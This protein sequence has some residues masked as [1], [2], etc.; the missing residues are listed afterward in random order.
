MLLKKA[1]L[2]LL[3]RNFR[4]VSNLGCISKLH[5]AATQHINHIESNSLMEKHQSAYHAL[6]STETVLLKVKTD[7]IRALENHEVACLVFLDLSTAFNTIDYNILLIRMETLFAVT[8][9]TLNWFR[10]YL[11]DRVQAIVI[12][13]LLLDGSKLA[14]IPLTSGILQ[15]SVLGPILFILYT[16]PLGDLCRKT[17]IKFHLYADI[18]KST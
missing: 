7:V 18:H 10:S 13:D 9:V 4:P 12:G 14:S 3:D 11:T 16:V 1:N 8:G 6:H 17:G 5:A 15:G 2:D